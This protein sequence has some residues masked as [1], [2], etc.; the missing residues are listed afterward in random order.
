MTYKKNHPEKKFMDD[1]IKVL[2]KYLL[3][4]SLI[5]LIMQRKFNMF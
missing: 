2:M 3:I 5:L 1:F 4:K